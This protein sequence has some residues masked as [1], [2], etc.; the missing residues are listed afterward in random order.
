MQLILGNAF[1]LAGC[2]VMVAIGL[3]REKKKILLA[4]SAQFALMAVGNM[5][6]GG[7][8]GFIANLVS[9]VRNLLFAQKRG[10]MRF[11]KIG[12]ILLQLALSLR[13]MGES[14]REWV[15][16]LPVVAAAVFTWFLD[17]KSEVCLKIVILV[18]QL[19]WLV[20]DIHIQNYVTVAFDI[21]TFISTSVG[22]GMILKLRRERIEERE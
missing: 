10:D 15:S 6:L 12:F 16:W 1:A 14:W 20:Y 21:F 7:L 8:T 11:W 9:I 2:L 13:V 5:L 17:T 22:L 18:T 3:V 19:M 4:Q